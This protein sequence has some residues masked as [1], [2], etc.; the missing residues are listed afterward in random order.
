MM[1]AYF[2]SLWMLTVLALCVS[3]VLPARVFSPLIVPLLPGVLLSAGAWFFKMPEAG[4][5]TSLIFAGFVAIGYGACSASALS[6]RLG[7]ASGLAFHLLLAFAI[8]EARPYLDAKENPLYISGFVE[9]SSLLAALTAGG[10]LIARAVEWM[11]QA[12]ERRMSADRESGRKT[13]AATAPD[14][15]KGAR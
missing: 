4:A 3:R 12:E 5:H 15:P 8:P 7:L 13:P 2:F 1:H 10:L 14:S 6:A 9:A 11:D